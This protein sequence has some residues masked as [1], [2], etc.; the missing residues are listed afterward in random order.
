MSGGKP[1]LRDNSRVHRIMYGGFYST[2]LKMWLNYFSSSHIMIIP[3]ELFWTEDV[4]DSF[5]KLQEVLGIPHFDY[6]YV[7]KRNMHDGRIEIKSPAVFLNSFFNSNGRVPPMLDRTRKYLN[8]FYCES[9]MEL[10]RMLGGRKLP[11]YS[12]TGVDV[13]Q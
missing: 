9:N 1:N 6:R 7:T 4:L 10:G 8:D 5:D 13:A 12:C 3:S 11:G 2:Y